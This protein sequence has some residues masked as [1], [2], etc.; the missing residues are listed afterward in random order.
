MHLP[1]RQ[2]Y[3][4][5]PSPA[6]QTVR[7]LLGS[8]RSLA[9]SHGLV[10]LSAGLWPVLSIGSFERVTGP[11]TDRWLV[12]TVGSLIAVAGGAGL[13]AARRDRVTPEIVGLLVGVSSVLAG[14]SFWYARQ[15]RISRIYYFDTLLEAALVGAWLVEFTGANDSKQALSPDRDSGV[16]LRD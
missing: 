12:K 13:H 11:K 3:T 16:T 14:V 1:H 8:R 10:F 15:G 9:R 2:D 5:R 6:R 7:A 4:P